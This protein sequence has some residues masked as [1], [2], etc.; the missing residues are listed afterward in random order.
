LS[1]GY[2]TIAYDPGVEARTRFEEQLKMPCASN[3]QEI[4]DSRPLACIV[5][6]T[7]EFH[8]DLAFQALNH[9]C[10]V[11]IEKPVSHA[12]RD[13][14]ELVELCREKGA[15]GMV[16]CNM[17]FHPGV[18]IV[19][20]LV[21]DGSTGPII[22]A[23]LHTGSFLPDW[24]PWTDYRLGHSVDGTRGGGTLL[25]CIHEIDIA[26]WLF[27]PA[28]LAGAATV[29]TYLETPKA[30][31]L[32][33]LLLQ[34]DSGVLSSIHLNFVQR[35]YRRFYELIGEKGTI[36]WDF[37][38]TDVVVRRGKGEV[39][40]VG[41]GEQWNVNQMYIDELVYFFECVHQKQT[42]FSTIEDGFN[43]LK[44]ALH[45]R[46]HSQFSGAK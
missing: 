28:R 14:P 43:A 7:P 26:L 5:A 36:Y 9:G 3:I 8:V 24:R 11:L 37:H 4:W 44:I 32:A 1:L 40:N 23:R 25:E 18:Q 17:R 19:Q 45:A 29:S 38:R 42:P 6:A 13:L 20:R 22:A 34:H 39:E 21:A 12:L 46:S 16:C 2:R 33:E 35:D 27:G 30:E 15:T 31:S 10:H 41:I